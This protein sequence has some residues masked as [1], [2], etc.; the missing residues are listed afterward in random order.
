VTAADHALPSNLE[1]ATSHAREALSGV[2]QTWL[3]QQLAFFKL[4]EENQ[5]GAGM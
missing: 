1:I 5:T 4:W 3:D 2:R